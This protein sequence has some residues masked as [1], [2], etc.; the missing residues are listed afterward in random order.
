MSCTVCELC[1]LIP[2]EAWNRFVIF[3]FNHVVAVSP[4]TV[5]QLL[6][7][8]RTMSVTFGH[9][10]KRRLC[11]IMVLRELTKYRCRLYWSLH[12]PRP[13]AEL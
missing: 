3:G 4:L 5:S 9:F 11:K 2:L 6:K 12:Q 10:P 1:S 8:V 7:V 13:T